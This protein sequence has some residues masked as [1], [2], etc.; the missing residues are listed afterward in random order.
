MSASSAH[1][2]Q[3]GPVEQV[4]PIGLAGTGS[5]AAAPARRI[6]SRPR[7]G[8]GSGNSSGPVDQIA[9]QLGRAGL[10]IELGRVAVGRQRG[11]CGPRRSA[12]GSAR[13]RECSRHAQP[14]YAAKTTANMPERIRPSRTQ[15]PGAGRSSSQSPLQVQVTTRNAAG[16]TASP[17]SGSMPAKSSPICI[18]R[19]PARGTSATTPAVIPRGNAI[20]QSTATAKPSGRPRASRVHCSAAWEMQSPV[21]G[22]PG[23]PAG[24]RS[25]PGRS[26]RSSAS[27]ARRAP[28]APVM[29]EEAIGPPPVLQAEDADSRDQGDQPVAGQ[30]EVG[31]AQVDDKCSRR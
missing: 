14:A 24:A 31:R 26:T 1:R 18:R 5:R 8:S 16:K 10:A 28:A 6:R 2:R 19:G 11:R 12:S 15:R 4:E 25:A 27:P 13:R 3:V 23:R 17:Q 7:A 9:S 30:G 22:S 29:D 21:P 20:P